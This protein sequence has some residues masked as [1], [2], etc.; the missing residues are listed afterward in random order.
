M[1]YLQIRIASPHPVDPARLGEAATRLMAEVMHKRREVTVVEVV[2]S[3]GAW[4]VDGAPVSGPAVQ[5]DIKITRGTN[6]EAEKARLLAAFQGL[7]RET[8]GD[9]AAPAYVVIHEIAATDWG[10]DGL[11]QA[12]RLTA[13]R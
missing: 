1:P 2:P 4:F 11:P 13:K 7:L 5:A 3:A 6:T 12:A 10:Y 9:L 8:L